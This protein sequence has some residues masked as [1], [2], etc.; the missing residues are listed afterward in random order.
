[1][2]CDAPAQRLVAERQ[3]VAQRV[4]L[5]RRN[6]R[7]LG[8]LRCRR[9]GLADLHVDNAAPGPLLLGGR[10]HHVHDHEALD[11]AALRSRRKCARRRRKPIRGCTLFHMLS[12]TSA[13]LFNQRRGHSQSRPIL[14][15]HSC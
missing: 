1:V 2:P 11:L 4:G 8:G 14:A 3:G 15:C 6:R 9:A 12:V 13:D 7:A 5:D 10:A